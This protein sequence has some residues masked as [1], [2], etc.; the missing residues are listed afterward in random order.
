MGF[1]TTSYPDSI[2]KVDTKVIEP[3]STLKNVMTGERF[4]IG[5]ENNSFVFYKGKHNEY[6]PT[7]SIPSEVWEN[8]KTLKSP[9][10]Y[11]KPETNYEEAHS[12]PE[13]SQSTVNA[14]DP[15][16]ND[17]KF[18]EY[19]RK[20]SAE[21]GGSL[22][23]FSVESRAGML[24]KELPENW[25]SNADK[26]IHDTITESMD[27]DRKK[28]LSNSQRTIQIKSWNNGQ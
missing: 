7:N 25:I 18:E 27:E 14:I 15:A 9:S 2:I 24:K 5:V 11:A 21:R 13:S 26:R 28:E 4:Q 22:S 1:A 8:L 6:A 10:E 19:L 20:L 12:L 23:A 3:I 17:D 16:A